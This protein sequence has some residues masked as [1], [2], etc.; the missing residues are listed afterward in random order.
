MAQPNR[1]VRRLIYRQSR[2]KNNSA[3]RAE[4]R[5]SDLE[6]D[7]VAQQAKLRNLEQRIVVLETP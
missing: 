6:T 5:I 4:K 7:N 1:I 2:I 3:R